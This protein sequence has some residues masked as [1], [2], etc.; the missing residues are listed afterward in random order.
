MT[1]EDLDGLIRLAI[2]VEEHVE[3]ITEE[4]YTDGLPMDEGEVALRIGAMQQIVGHINSAVRYLDEAR[5]A[6]EL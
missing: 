2:A 3:A 1:S 5:L 4:L 6:R